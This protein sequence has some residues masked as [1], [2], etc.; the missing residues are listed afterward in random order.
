MAFSFGFEEATKEVELEILHRAASEVSSSLFRHRN[1]TFEEAI[2]LALNDLA[3]KYLTGIKDLESIFRTLEVNSYFKITLEVL[4]KLFRVG[5]RLQTKNVEEFGE[6]LQNLWKDYSPHAPIAHLLSSLVG[7]TVSKP[8]SIRYLTG[9]VYDPKYRAYAFSK[10]YPNLNFYF[11]SYKEFK[12]LSDPDVDNSVLMNFI[13]SFKEGMSRI[14][15]EV[16]EFYTSIYAGLTDVGTIQD[17]LDHLVLLIYIK[18]KSWTLK[19]NDSVFKILKGIFGS[20]ETTRLELKYSGVSNESDSIDTAINTLKKYLDYDLDIILPVNKEVSDS[21]FTLKVAIEQIAEIRGRKIVLDSSLQKKTFV[22]GLSIEERNIFFRGLTGSN[23]TDYLQQMATRRKIEVNVSSLDSMA[24]E[25][26]FLRLFKMDAISMMHHALVEIQPSTDAGTGTVAGRDV[27]VKY[28]RA[29]AYML[30]A[31]GERVNESFDG[32]IKFKSLVRGLSEIELEEMSKI[33]FNTPNGSWE[34]VHNEYIKI[35][36][37][38]DNVKAGPDVS[39]IDEITEG[40]KIIK[41]FCNALI[42]YA[43]SP[44]LSVFDITIDIINWVRENVNDI[45]IS[46]G[47]DDAFQQNLG[48]MVIFSLV[49]EVTTIFPKMQDNKHYVVAFL[50]AMITKEKIYTDLLNEIAKESKVLFNYTQMPMKFPIDAQPWTIANEIWIRHLEREV[51]VKT[52]EK[53]I[54]KKLTPEEKARR[55]Y[56]MAENASL[57]YTLSLRTKEVG[58]LTIN[59]E[60]SFIE[61]LKFLRHHGVEELLGTEF[62]LGD[63]FDIGSIKLRDAI[64]QL[65]NEKYRDELE[66]IV[67]RMEHGARF[68]DDTILNFSGSIIDLF[69]FSIIR[70]T[71]YVIETEYLDSIRSF[72]TKYQPL[73][74]SVNFSTVQLRTK[75]RKTIINDMGRDLSTLI[76]AGKENNRLNF[77]SELFSSVLEL[78]VIEYV[79]KINDLTEGTPEY[80]KKMEDFAR[81]LF[82]K[83]VKKNSFTVLLNHLMNESIKGS[84]EIGTDY[85]K[86]YADRCRYILRR[87]DKTIQILKKT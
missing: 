75:S 87:I 67:V 50:S 2:D 70:E 53:E 42:K 48:K 47:S 36:I 64:L 11:E 5:R 15:P 86:R 28:E 8:P 1:K 60:E 41:E 65:L 52:K 14:L 38:K 31:R 77:F 20:E 12:V 49:N 16:I 21:D 37:Q 45:F 85:W 56:Q 84:A 18:L 33:F 57:K 26:L 78:P 71:E 24:M 55:A 54:V 32:G 7:N 44:A 66:K 46:L 69:N 3:T 58:C 23:F 9:N 35:L 39:T 74:A 27:L 22:Q 25:E 62:Q 6:F 76:E 83:G 29:T 80:Q 43:L 82:G 81:Y 17:V 10:N 59:Q 34:E 73:F 63:S 61:F 68:D 4:G 72:A 51:K 30:K 79:I 13:A 19:D 40:S